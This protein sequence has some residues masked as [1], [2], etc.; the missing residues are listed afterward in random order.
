MSIP[1]ITTAE[2]F[3]IAM[4]LVFA[5]PCLIWRLGRTEYWAPLVV[6]PR[7]RRVP[8]SFKSAST[9]RSKASS[10][11]SGLRIRW[12]ALPIPTQACA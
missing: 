11:W 6:V 10:A 12:Y 5:V 7:L 3:L 4:I 9:A 8:P 2:L 1:S